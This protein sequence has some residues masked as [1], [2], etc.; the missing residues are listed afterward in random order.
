[1]SPW[2]LRCWDV[3]S[4]CKRKVCYVS[5]YLLA[6]P[7]SIWDFYHFVCLCGDLTFLCFVWSMIDPIFP[8]YLQHKSWFGLLDHSKNN[9]HFQLKPEIQSITKYNSSV[10]WIT[11]Q[12]LTQNV[13]VHGAIALNQIV[14]SLTV[15]KWSTI[16]CCFRS[17]RL[18]V[19]R[20]NFSF[21]LS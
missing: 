13:K 20:Q 1:M 17:C 10:K 16:K 21:K 15:W 2:L 9:G 14:P 8:V 4:T 11:I 12:N 19:R 6:A 3:E 18:I 7:L 5:T